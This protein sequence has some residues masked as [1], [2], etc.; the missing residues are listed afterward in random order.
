[1]YSIPQMTP[2]CQLSPYYSGMNNLENKAIRDNQTTNRA[3]RLGKI[4]GDHGD[5]L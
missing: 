2:N 1:M 3:S 5:E 4:D